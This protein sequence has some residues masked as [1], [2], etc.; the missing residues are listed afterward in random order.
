MLE[1]HGRPEMQL[2]V[3]ICNVDDSAP[4]GL[5]IIQFTRLIYAHLP[6]RK[7]LVLFRHCVYFFSFLRRF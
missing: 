4:L 3:Q 2:G 6:E 5:R 1:F 7:S